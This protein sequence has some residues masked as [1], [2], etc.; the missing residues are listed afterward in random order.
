MVKGTGLD[1]LMKPHGFW[2]RFVTG[3][4]IAA[5]ALGIHWWSFQS[6]KVD[7]MY[8]GGLLIGLFVGHSAACF[9]EIS[10][11]K[12]ESK[13]LSRGVYFFVHVGILFLFA[14]ISR[15]MLFAYFAALGVTFGFETAFAALV[16]KVQIPRKL[17][18]NI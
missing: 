6:G 14:F 15:N 4:V 3:N 1:R 9:V 16:K 7:A 2:D 17:G 11:E 13:F 5:V 18:K 8:F 10:G 12:P